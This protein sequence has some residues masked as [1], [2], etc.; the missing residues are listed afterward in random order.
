MRVTLLFITCLALTGIFFKSCQS[1]KSASSYNLSNQADSIQSTKDSISY[2]LGK[3][4]YKNFQKRGIEISEKLVARALLD[5]ANGSDTLIA[6]EQARPLMQQLQQ[7]MMKQRQQQRPGGRQQGPG[8]SKQEQLKKKLK[9]KMKKKQQ[10]QQ[11]KEKKDG[12]DQQMEESNPDN[13]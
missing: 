10:Q 3:N 7:Q 1:S 13:Q 5:A 8:G 4:M 2:V 6:E 9:E 12:G 11:M